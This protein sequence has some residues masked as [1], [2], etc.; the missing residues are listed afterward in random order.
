MK[1]AVEQHHQRHVDAALPQ[2][3]EHKGPPPLARGLKD[4]HAE[5]DEHGG[6]PGK[7]DDAQKLSAAGRRFDD[8]ICGQ[9]LV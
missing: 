4:G 8:L 3:G 2:Q 6:E 1:Q 7:A 9:T 5:K